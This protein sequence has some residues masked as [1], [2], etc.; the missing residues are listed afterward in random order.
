MLRAT[1][2]AGEG[3]SRTRRLPVGW[4]VITLL[5]VSVGVRVLNLAAYYPRTSNDSYGYLAL[6][7]MMRTGDFTGYDGW[8]TP[9]YPLLIAAAGGSYLAIELIQ[10]LLGVLAGLMLFGLA[11]RRTRSAG[12]ALVVGLVYTLSLNLLIYEVTVL[13]ETLSLSLIV[14]SVWLFDRTEGRG[15]ADMVA[16]LSVVCCAAALTRPMLLILVPIYAVFIW[17]ECG[18]GQRWRAAAAYLAPAF[19]LI[20]GWCGFN[21]VTVGSFALE[22]LTG[23][24]LVQHTGK[25]IERAPDEFA[26]FRDTHLKYRARS[27]TNAQVIFQSEGEMRQRTGLSRAALSRQLTRVS[28][29][30]I[31]RFPVPYLASVARSYKRFWTVWKPGVDDQDIT[32]PF[33]PFKFVQDIGWDVERRLLLVAYLLFA[34]TVCTAA[35]QLTRHRRT[36]LSRTELLSI[37]IVVCASVGQA[38]V[39]FGDNYRF[40]VPFMPLLYLVAVMHIWRAWTRPVTRP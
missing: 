39:T 25:F 40:L 21:K 2:D 22:T 17:T 19:V 13:T 15:R 6:A 34:A 9:G 14:L 31:V 30:L 33:R 36:G 3:R 23:Y 32:P 38:L 7:Q 28:L 26:V 29:W 27:T 37:V 11:V 18:P 16:L 8:R 24:N 35:Y 4:H 12:L 5:A 20:G 10:A 1:G